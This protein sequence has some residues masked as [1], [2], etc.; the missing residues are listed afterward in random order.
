MGGSDD[1]DAAFLAVEVSD[2]E[3]QVRK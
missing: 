1:D 3:F 2:G